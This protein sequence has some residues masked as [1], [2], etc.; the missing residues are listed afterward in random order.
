MTVPVTEWDVMTSMPFSAT[1]V[2]TALD[3]AMSAERLVQLRTR[4]APDERTVGYVLEAS[5]ELVVL[6]KVSDRSMGTR[7]FVCGT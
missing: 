1:D 5:D 3:R 6:Q 2:R 4:F 7:S